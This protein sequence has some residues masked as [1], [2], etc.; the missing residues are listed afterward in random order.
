MDETELRMQ[1]FVIHAINDIL[2]AGKSVCGTFK[3]GFFG[4]HSAKINKSL[5]VFQLN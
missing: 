3:F 4:C 2:F 1:L 5:L